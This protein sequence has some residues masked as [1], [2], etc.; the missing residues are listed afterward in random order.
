MNV[1]E[2]FFRLKDR[3]I[4]FKG[5]EQKK[6][7]AEMQA[8]FDSL[9]SEDSALLEEA[10]NEDFA[11]IRKDVAC[12]YQLAEQIS[13]RKQLESVLQFQQ[14]YTHNNGTPKRRIYNK[15]Q[16][17][18]YTLCHLMARDIQNLFRKI[19]NLDIRKARRARRQRKAHIVHPRRNHAVKRRIMRPRRTHTTLCR[20]HL[21]PGAIVSPKTKD[22]RRASG[23]QSKVCQKAH[24][25]I[26]CTK[27]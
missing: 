12:T 15:I 5:E 11:R 16:D 14:Q 17:E 25:L 24:L 19:I 1:K 3:W 13:I 20:Q 8:F 21:K 10:V 18:R 26:L 27:P 23:A 22:T 2:E 4:H 9:N 7:D 6:A